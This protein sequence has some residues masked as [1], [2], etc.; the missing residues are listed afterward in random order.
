MGQ[1]RERLTKFAAA[2]QRAQ[3]KRARNLLR[4]RQGKG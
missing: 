3:G 4:R 2:Q 1:Q